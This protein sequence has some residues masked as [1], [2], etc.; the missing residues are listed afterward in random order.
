MATLNGALAIHREKVVGQVAPGYQADLL[1]VSRKASE[2][3]YSALIQSTQ[4][5]VNLVV[6]SGEPLYGEPKYIEAAAQAAGDKKQAESIPS[7]QSACGFSKLLRLAKTSSYDD[8]L[9]SKEGAPKLST[10]AGIEKELSSKM[11][12][13]AT[14]VK[15]TASVKLASNLVPG[16]DPL[17]SCDDT[18][19]Q[20]RFDAFIEQE[21]DQNTKARRQVR[22]QYKLNDAWSPL[23]GGAEISEDSEDAESGS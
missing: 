3:P 23:K 16:V 18:A 8:E 22:T 14:E 9:A 12:A 1:L 19:Y 15:K 6:V 7:A 20:T 21:L 2:N 4:K 13:Y 11:K 10:L 17:F 5:D